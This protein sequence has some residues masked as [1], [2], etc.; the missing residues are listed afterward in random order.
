MER[1]E[2]VYMSTATR[3]NWRERVRDF[4]RDTSRELAEHYLSVRRALIK[5]LQD[6]G[7]GLLLGSDA[8]QMMNVPGFSIHEELA[9]MVHAG[10]T[11]YQALAMGTVN[12]AAF[13]SQVDHGQVA[14]DYVADLV[15]LEKNPL[16]DIS[17]TRGVVGVM[18]AGR[19]LDRAELDRALAAIRRRKI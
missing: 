3:A 6:E 17:N 7:A 9:Y 4:R 5:R 12:V 2:M 8:P 18:R 15:L 1:P 14:K 19:W 10:L 13:F 16:D 11:P